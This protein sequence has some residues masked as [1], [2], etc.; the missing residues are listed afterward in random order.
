[1]VTLKCFDPHIPESFFVE[2]AL[3]SDVCYVRRVVVIQPLDVLHHFGLVR[4][5][6]RQDQQILEV[7]KT[8]DWII[9]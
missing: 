9:I 2:L 7:P 1:M 6:R 4:L 8:I 3:D 5:D